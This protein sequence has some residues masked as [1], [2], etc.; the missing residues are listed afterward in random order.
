MNIAEIESLLKELLKMPF[1]AETFT[2]SIA[3]L[4]GSEQ[5]IDLKVC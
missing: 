3:K 2:G 1:D 4:V 5:E